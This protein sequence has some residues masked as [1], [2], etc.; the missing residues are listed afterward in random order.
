[1]GLV[2]IKVDNLPET[3]YHGTISIYRNSFEHK[4]INLKHGFNYVDFGPGFYTTSNREQA[5]TFAQRKAK[6]HNLNQEKGKEKDDKFVPQ[7]AN[8]MVIIYNLNIKELF[9]LSGYLFKEPDTKWGEFIFNNRLGKKYSISKF[10]NLEGNYDYVYGCMADAE[11]ALI[12]QDYK[13][14]VISYD[15]FTR[16]I[17]PYDQ[18]SQDQLSF[19]SK[20][21]LKCLETREY[22]IYRKGGGWQ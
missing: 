16:L 15:E 22:K 12:I 8:P 10:H 20:N 13:D 19:H 21:S 14:R 11:I 17:E 9:K 2:I 4:G 6:R 5:L 18:Y 7:F 1:M 3:I